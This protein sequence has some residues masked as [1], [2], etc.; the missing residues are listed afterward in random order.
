MQT[1]GLPIRNPSSADL[2][3]STSVISAQTCFQPSSITVLVS[4]TQAQAAHYT[5]SAE[6][7]KVDERIRAATFSPASSDVIT[8]YTSKSIRSFQFAI[9][10]SS[11][12]RS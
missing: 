10:S 1:G 12:R 7:R 4:R 11:S 2:P 3:I 6:R 5:G 8:G 9:H